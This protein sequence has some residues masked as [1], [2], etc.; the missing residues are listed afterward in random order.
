MIMQKNRNNIYEEAKKVFI[1]TNSPK[2]YVKFESN[3]R[4]LQHLHEFYNSDQK[5]SIIIGK[6]GIGKSM[7]LKRFVYENPHPKLLL[8]DKPFFKK[9]E[10]EKQLAKDLLGQNS[11]NFIEDIEKNLKDFEYT[12][13]LDEVQLYDD[14]MLEFVRIAS[15]TKKV[16]FILSLHEIENESALTKEHFTSR[17]FSY[18]TIKNPSLPELFV[19]F[20]K[21]LLSSNLYELSESLKKKDFQFI[22]QYTQGNLRD[23]NKFL[24]T[25]FDILSYFNENKPST[26]KSLKIPKKFLEMSAIH[27]GYI[28]A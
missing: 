15:D 7:L 9:Y 20:Q 6:P 1:D 11:K 2:D 8:Y 19:Y 26:L 13:I 17:I 10:L 16:K 5:I 3:I 22:Y 21:K 18:I 28:N 12:V 23:T 27:L 14:Y 24:Y 25:L 4:Y